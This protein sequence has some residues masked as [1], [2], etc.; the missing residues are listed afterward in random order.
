MTAA[1]TDRPIKLTIA[2]LG[3][4]GG[5][6]LAD[7]LLHLAES[8]SWLV[9][10]TSVPG[11][12]QRTGATIYYLELFPRAAMRGGRE[13]IMALM[14][15]P[16]DVDCVIAS[17]LAEAGRVIQRGLVT[18]DRTTLIASSHRAYTISERSA[19]GDGALDALALAAVT[20]EQAKRVIMFDM[21]ELASRHGAFISA[22]LF[23]A[24]AGSGVL[25]F[26]RNDFEQAIRD[27]GGAAVA[28]SLAAFADAFVRAAAGTVAQPAGRAKPE[29]PLPQ[30]ARSATGQRLLDRVRTFP[31]LVQETALIGVRR[32]I[33]YQDASYAELY[34]QRLERIL[35][36]DAPGHELTQ[37][38]AR[39]LALWMSF[40]DTIRV[41]DL[42]TRANRF[43]R[44]REDMRVET[45]QLLEI[46]E[47]MKPRVAEIAGTLPAKLGRWVERSPRGSRL[48][49]RFAAGR[50]IRSTTIGGFL[51]LRAVASLRRVRRATL[52]YETEDERIEQWLAVVESMAP[53]NH[54]CALEIARLQRLVKGYGDTHERG[55]RNFDSIMQR[56]RRCS[57]GDEDASMI[58]R[59]LEAALADEEGVAL[60]RELAARP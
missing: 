54:A 42:K 29:Q 53:T 30:R 34:L 17:E 31:V 43:T 6:V 9:Q 16:G 1:G 19:M 57:G 28:S 26:A 8:R 45:G 36:V 13:P 47:F 2:A 27:S 60:R 15:T 52:R 5:G 23:G 56:A 46:T 4:Q 38:M 37:L 39:H 12:A 21:E 24:I 35:A 58:A 48:L 32:L 18:P 25:P 59:L 7:W 14:P 51:L 55:T 41:A 49:G 3:G 33:D 10:S 50:R 11:V 44:V 20:V 22:V 40:E